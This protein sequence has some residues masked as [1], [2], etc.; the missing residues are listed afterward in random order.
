MLQPDSPD[1]APQIIGGVESA[2]NSHPYA[3]TL[4]VIQTTGLWRFVC[5]GT[6]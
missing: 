6:Q 1:Y 4:E 2:P 3:C 5:L